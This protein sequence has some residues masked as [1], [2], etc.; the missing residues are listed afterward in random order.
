[1]K[2][3]MQMLHQIACLLLNL[4]N[5]Q[6]TPTKIWMHADLAR[7]EY[8]FLENKKKHSKKFMELKRYGPDNSAGAIDSWAAS[9]DNQQL[10][11]P[12][13]SC[14]SRPIQ[15]QKKSRSLKFRI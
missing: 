6:M 15:S 9:W 7:Q 4:F 5:F 10:R 8:F 12:T 2:S 1:M 11:A 13:T 3:K 14:K